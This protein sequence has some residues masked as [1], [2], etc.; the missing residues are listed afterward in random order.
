MR[1]LVVTPA[2]YHHPLAFSAALGYG[3]ARFHRA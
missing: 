1:W 2:S 3:N